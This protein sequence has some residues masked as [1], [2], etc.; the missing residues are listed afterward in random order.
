MR[1]LIRMFLTHLH[2]A[3][4]SVSS[5]ELFDVQGDCRDF[6]PFNK[7]L[8]LEIKKLLKLYMQRINELEPQ[9]G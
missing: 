5:E 6:F 9:K 3:H 2:L 8:F 4:Q 7:P 1:N